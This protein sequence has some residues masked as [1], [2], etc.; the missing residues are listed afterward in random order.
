[1]IV[2]EN[3]ATYVRVFEENEELIKGVNRQQQVQDECGLVGTVALRNTPCEL[4]RRC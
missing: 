3:R 1:M 2:Q 4:F